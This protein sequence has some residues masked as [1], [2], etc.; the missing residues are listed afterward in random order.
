[1]REQWAVIMRAWDGCARAGARTS[2][3]RA[4]CSRSGFCRIA[5]RD[6]EVRTNQITAVC[7]FG[8]AGSKW[9]GIMSGGMSVLAMANRRAG[10]PVVSHVTGTSEVRKFYLT[11][12]QLNVFNS[13]NLVLMNLA[14]HE[15][16]RLYTKPSFGSFA[17]SA[18]TT[19]PVFMSFLVNALRG[20]AHV[21]N[22]ALLA[23][24]TLCPVVI[25][26]YMRAPSQDQV[27]HTLVSGSLL[28][29]LGE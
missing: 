11:S 3:G 21:L 14:L 13:I 1:M 22:Y 9:A 24:A 18:F 28:R 5:L 10:I 12:F 4:L 29:I 20:N 16:D 26:T 23:G 6:L 15:N 17:G 8:L 27:E 7:S 19:S 25:F 2:D